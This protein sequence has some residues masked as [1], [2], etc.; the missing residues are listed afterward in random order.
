MDSSVSS[1]RI[2]ITRLSAVGDCVLTLP[3]LSALRRRWP[4]AWIAWAAESAACKLL[5][6]LGAE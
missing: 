1:P 4:K 2:L 6:G 5:Q 3:L